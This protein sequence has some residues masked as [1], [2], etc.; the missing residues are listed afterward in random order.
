M[1]KALKLIVI[2]GTLLA[3]F[4]SSLLLYASN[5]IYN[6]ALDP[7]SDKSMFLEH[8]DQTVSAIPE[9]LFDVSEDVSITS[10]DNLQLHGY[11]LEQKSKT[12]VIVVHGYM[13]ESKEMGWAIKH[14]Y[15][16]GYNVLAP[17][18]RGHGKSEGDYI[19]MGWDDRLDVVEWIDYLL[20][21]DKDSQIILFGV[22]MGGATVMNVGGEDIPKNVKMIIEDSGYTSARDVFSYHLE[23]TFEIPEF[24]LLATASMVTKMRAGYSIEEGPINQIKNCTLPILFIHGNKDTFIPIEMMEK[25]YNKYDG[26]KEKLIIPNAGHVKSNDVDFK[27]YW[28]TVDSFI[29][30]HLE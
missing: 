3:F 30:K 22:S 19:G 20:N 13:S 4:A 25:L 27:K 16:M 21:I 12:W 1:K 24:P 15:Q 5:Y 2:T 7:T 11:S 29:V 9:V 23:N 10:N 28:K 26:I 18:L 14:F 17:D 6:L 8:L